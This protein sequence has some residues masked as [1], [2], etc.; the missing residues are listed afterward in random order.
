MLVADRRVPVRMGVRLWTFP[1]FMGV[2]VVLVMDVEMFV[3]K[4][5]VDMLDL[6][7]VARRP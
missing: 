3:P 1:A 4:R 7:L 2:L 5:P 6:H